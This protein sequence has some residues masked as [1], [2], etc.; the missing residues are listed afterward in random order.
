MN[1]MPPLSTSNCFN[2][3]EVYSVE[4]SSIDLTDETIAKDVQP[5]PE[6]LPTPKSS[7]TYPVRLERWERQ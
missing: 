3:L 4:D 1:R 5:T 6:A 2:I 7:P